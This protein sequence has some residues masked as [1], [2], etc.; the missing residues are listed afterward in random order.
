MS[1]PLIDLDHLAIASRHAEDMARTLIEEFGAEFHDGGSFGDMRAIQVRLPTPE[2]STKLELIEPGL[3]AVGFLDA[4]LS[5]RGPG[6]HHLTFRT[7]AIDEAVDDIRAH[8]IEPTGVRL[9]GPVQREAFISPRH[10]FGIVIQVVEKADVNRLE[11]S[12]A[13]WYREAKTPWWSP[14]PE[15][16]DQRMTIHTVVLRVRDLAK[17]VGLYTG[18]LRGVAAG[19]GDGWV[20]LRWPSACVRLVEA[21]PDGFSHLEVA[22]PAVDRSRTAC[23]VLLHPVEGSR[24]TAQRA[25][26]SVAHD[27]Q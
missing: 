20:D 26:S 24:P 5:R 18:P 9:D 14:L 1:S 4:F 13:Q 10:G 6:V 12:V 11:P 7:D 25:S 21:E 22:S 23:E 17:A 3:R 2:G 15:R 27:S 19:E 8:G 16:H